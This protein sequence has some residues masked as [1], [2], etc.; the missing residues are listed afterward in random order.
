MTI[1]VLDG[2]FIEV[3][4]HTHIPMT[5]N[6]RHIINYRGIDDDKTLVSDLSA[7]GNK[8]IM[9]MHGYDEVKQAIIQA[10]QK[11]AFKVLI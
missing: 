7:V 2:G 5:I 11:I 4:L 1:P 3:M 6:A 9:V 10:S 8:G